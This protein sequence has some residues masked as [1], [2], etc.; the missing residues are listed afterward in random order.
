M[1]TPNFILSIITVI[2]GLLLSASLH[3]AE[4]VAPDAEMTTDTNAIANDP[5][6]GGMTAKKITADKKL[7]EMEQTLRN[8]EA[9]NKDSV[10][11]KAQLAAFLLSQNKATES[12]PFYQEAITLSPENP[13]LFASLSIAYL[14][15]AEYS[16]AKA[17]ADEALRLSPD[18]KQAKK[19]NEY[20]TTKQEVLEMRDKAASSDQITPN[21]ETHNA[22]PLHTPE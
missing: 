13:K 20:I 4:P 1:N 19:L 12:I 2:P 6:I 8:A 14:H 10:Q 17:M 9:Q 21:D 15:R 3:A 16:M 7:E 11:A 5:A 18:M 22:K